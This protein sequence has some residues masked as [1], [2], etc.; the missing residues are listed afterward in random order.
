MFYNLTQPFIPP[1]ELNILL[2]DSAFAEMLNVIDV[3][4]GG[5]CFDV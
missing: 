2:Q 3:K 4:E 1:I 5:D